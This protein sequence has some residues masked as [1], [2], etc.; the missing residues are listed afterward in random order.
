MHPLEPRQLLSSA[1]LTNGTLVITGRETKPN[2]ISATVLANGN[3]EVAINGNVPNNGNPFTAVSDI[4]IKGLGGGDN[5]VLDESSAVTPIPAQ[6]H[7]G[8]GNDII[9]TLG[10][11]PSFIDGGNG[12]DSIQAGN[13]N[14]V[15]RGGNGPDTISVGTGNNIVLGGN[16]RNVINGSLG[17]DTLLGGDARDSITGGGGNDLIWGLE[18][19]DTLVG[20]IDGA[21]GMDTI[22]AGTGAHD[23]IQP[24]F[25]DQVD[26]NGRIRPP[27][28]KQVLASFEA[29]KT[30]PI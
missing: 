7:G 17:N 18:G 30:V 2:D 13:G 5:I 8:N 26:P 12:A 10:A 21:S 6:I 25:S 1:I 27:H 16:G 24:G 29:D 4:K 22:Y 14:N 9:T 23:S 28:W 15:I 11:E 20:N 19:N 3:V